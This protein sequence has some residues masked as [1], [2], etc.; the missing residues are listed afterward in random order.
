MNS[1]HAAIE[2]ISHAI[3]GLSDCQVTK[4]RDMEEFITYIMISGGLVFVLCF[5]VLTGCIIALHK[6]Q[7]YVWNLLLS[8]VKENMLTI[9]SNVRSRL[10]RVHNIVD[11][12]ENE[13]KWGERRKLKISQWGK[14]MLIVTIL[15]LIMLSFYLV[16][17]FSFYKSILEFLIFR[18][19]LFN[20][21][22]NRRSKLMHTAFFTQEIYADSK[23]L[24]L[25]KNFYNITRYP[26]A[27]YNTEK[28]NNDLLILRK[29]FDTEKFSEITP[30]TVWDLIFGSFDSENP[31]LKCGIAASFS[32]AKYDGFNIEA[33]KENSTFEDV[34]MYL[35]DVY[36]T[37]LSYE[38]LN[39]IIDNDLN[40][41]IER[42]LF[43]LVTFDLLGSLLVIAA[44]LGVYWVYFEK[45]QMSVR[46]IKSLLRLIPETG[47][48][49]ERSTIFISF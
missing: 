41:H 20:V 45:E 18:L 49:L 26:D 29:N 30:S 25:T 40:D 8:K 6:K 13:E 28:I 23:N 39:P 4:T 44:S 33:N 22:T 14:Y 3:N 32:A 42:L 24:S 19:Q 11:F 12:E 16:F 34:R 47:F 48:S 5:C 27:E 37:F 46:Q 17:Y 36:D 31:K 1:F 15:G 21:M 35:K 10:S 38:I 9:R 43:W 7:E 2:E